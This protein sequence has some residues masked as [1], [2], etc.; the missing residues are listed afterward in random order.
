VAL[1]NENGEA[2]QFRW[3]ADSLLLE[4]VGLDGVARSIAMMPADAR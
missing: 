4:E 3:G 2:Y 1:E